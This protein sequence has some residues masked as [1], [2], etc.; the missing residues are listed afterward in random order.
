MYKEQCLLFDIYYINAQP[1]RFKNG[2]SALNIIEWRVNVRCFTKIFLKDFQI[3][4]PWVINSL[5]GGNKK[6]PHT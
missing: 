6:V 2:A 1:C 4:F 3:S 5:P